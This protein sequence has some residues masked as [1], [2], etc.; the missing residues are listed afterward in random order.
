[1]KSNFF[2][3][4]IVIGVS[5]VGAPACLMGQSV[6]LQVLTSG[7]QDEDGVVKNGMP[8]G[9]VIDVSGGS[10]DFSALSSGLL[11]PISSFPSPET[12]TQLETSGGGT[13]FYFWRANSDTTNSGPPSFLDGFMNLATVP[14]NDGTPTPVS[15]GNP[16]GI[17]WFSEADASLGSFYGFHDTGLDLPP[18]GSNPDISSSVTPGAADLEIVPEPASYA[19]LAGLLGLGLAILRR[20]RR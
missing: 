20:R 17:L 11:L 16:Y 2:L 12:M 14:V 3:V 8:W 7:F 15:S 13:D 1:M 6:A 19:L 18:Q 10:R 4:A 5:I 9:I